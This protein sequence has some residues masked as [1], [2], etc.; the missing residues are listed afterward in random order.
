MFQLLLKYSCGIFISDIMSEKLFRIRGRCSWLDCWH[1][2][3]DYYNG[4]N[5]IICLNCNPLIW[6]CSEAGKPLSIFLIKPQIMN[7]NRVDT[8]QNRAKKRIETRAH[9]KNNHKDLLLS[10][11]IESLLKMKERQEEYFNST[12]GISRS[13]KF[14]R[15]RTTIFLPNS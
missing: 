5:H 10:K 15:I 6:E 11:N 9:R 12:M 7:K 13:T 2:R 14:S 8:E 4:T 1:Y 3:S